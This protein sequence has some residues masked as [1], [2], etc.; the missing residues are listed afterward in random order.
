MPPWQSRAPSNL[1]GDERT[2]PML[3]PGRGRTKSGQLWACAADDQP[4]GGADPPDFASVNPCNRKADGPI[5]HL[6]GFKGVLQVGGCAPA[7]ANWPSAATFSSHSAGRTWGVT[8]IS[9]PPRFRAHC[10]GGTSTNTRQLRRVLIRLVASSR[11]AAKGSSRPWRARR[12][13]RR[14]PEAARC[15]VLTLYRRHNLAPSAGR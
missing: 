7:M 6:A 12:G 9:L 3:N 14:E 15:R 13:R 8:D 5:A 4:S 10:T 11:A 1:L 2:I